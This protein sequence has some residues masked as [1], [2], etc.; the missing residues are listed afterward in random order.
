[1]QNKWL[2]ERVFHG[3]EDQVGA[4]GVRGAGGGDGGGHKQN[5]KAVD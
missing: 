3:V 5:Q 4:G 1:M 2:C